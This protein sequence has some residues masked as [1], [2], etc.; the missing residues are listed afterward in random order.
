VHYSSHNF[1]RYTIAH[2]D[3]GTVFERTLKSNPK[4]HSRDYSIYHVKIIRLPRKIMKNNE[5]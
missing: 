4:R 2:S 5:K 3:P 1:Q